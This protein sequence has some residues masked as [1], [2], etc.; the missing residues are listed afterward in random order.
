VDEDP[1]VGK[2]PAEDP[3]LAVVPCASPADSSCAGAESEGDMAAAGGT[4]GGADPEGDAATASGMVAGGSAS[5]NAA[6]SCR[7]H[8]MKLQIVLICSCAC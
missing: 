2:F 7:T 3:E 6:S 5:A 4:V 8:K 1:R